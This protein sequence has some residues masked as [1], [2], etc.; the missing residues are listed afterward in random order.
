[1]EA[2][3]CVTSYRERVRAG[4]LVTDNEQLAACKQLDALSRKIKNNLESNR[5]LKS[6]FA[7]TIFKEQHFF[8]YNGIYLYGGVG[9]G[10]S[11]LM[12][13]FFDCLRIQKKTRVH[14]HKFMQDTHSSI[15]RARSKGSVDPISD[16]AS[17]I[18]N[19]TS[20]LCFDEL[21]IT[22]I[23]DAMIVGRLF[24]KLI[25]L[26]TFL[27]TTSNRHP[28]ELYK[29]GLNRSLFVPFI[30][31]LKDNTN[32]LLLQT[33]K[34]YR[35][36]KIAGHEVY[37]SPIT[38]ET[39]RL[40]DYLSNSLLGGVSEPIE[41]SINKRKFVIKAY[42]SG[43]GRV[44]FF[45]LC[46]KPLGANDYIEL[47]SHI[48]VLF[49]ENIPVLNEQGMDSARRFVTLIDTLYEARVK[50]II[51]AED[52][53]EKL[54]TKGTGSFE[55]KRTISRLYEMQSLDWTSY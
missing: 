4:E 41:I 16:V 38:D 29:D 25:E 43:V 6:L 52:I 45:D 17:K 50:V 47:C 55:F 35:R 8:N 14:F 18:A 44:N 51:L 48:R 34:D 42:H 49:I 11:M 19:T 13:I 32:V 2:V 27:V 1:M 24:A 23:T 5:F 9:T 15:N 3:S 37:L 10:K 39:T 40:F 28:D 36:E 53:P 20:V 22:D 26:E 7:R 31:L 33:S 54:Y 12:D 21:Q 46:G 30:Q